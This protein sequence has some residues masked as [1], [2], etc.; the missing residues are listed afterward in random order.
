MTW[1]LITF[2]VTAWTVAY[3]VYHDKAWV[4]TEC[5]KTATVGL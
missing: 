3:V 2:V 4:Q 1:L 5:D